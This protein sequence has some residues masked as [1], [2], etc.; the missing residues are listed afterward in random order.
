MD[1]GRPATRAVYAAVLDRRIDRDGD[2]SL[3]G[4]PYSVSALP[5]DDGG[6]R[7][8]NMHP[9]REP[10]D[11]WCDRPRRWPPTEHRRRYWRST[12]RRTSRAD[13]IRRRRTED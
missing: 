12:S 4:Q 7:M 6:W 11:R 10:Q 5:L 13:G 8:L 3:P 1:R 2:L 9:R